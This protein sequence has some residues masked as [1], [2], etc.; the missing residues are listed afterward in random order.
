MQQHGATAYHHCEVKEE[1]EYA[2]NVFRCPLVPGGPH[3]HHCKF[4]VPMVRLTLFY[5]FQRFNI[6]FDPDDGL[7]T[8]LFQVFS[9]TN[10]PPEQLRLFGLGS[11]P[12]SL[13]TVPSDL[14][15]SDGMFI[16]MIE[17]MLPL[18]TGMFVD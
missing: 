11:G 17:P 2:Q 16:S 14:A 5:G 15:F 8:L 6:D 9:V 18:T 4:L 13:S 10:V 1:M 3:Q 12:A 7:E